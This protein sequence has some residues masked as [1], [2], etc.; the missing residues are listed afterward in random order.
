MSRGMK[1]SRECS[2]W[3]DCGANVSFF[4]LEPQIANWNWTFLRH[5]STRYRLG[6]KWYEFHT[7][8]VFIANFHTIHWHAGC[9]R[10]HRHKE[11]AAWNKSKIKTAI[12]LDW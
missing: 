4:R 8:N 3:I 2:V 6:W 7:R 10:I 5:N 1:L 12:R 11:F 9:R